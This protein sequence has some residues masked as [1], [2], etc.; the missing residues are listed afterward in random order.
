MAHSNC[1][2]TLT[3]SP[4]PTV[5]FWSLTFKGKNYPAHWLALSCSCIFLVTHSLHPTVCSRSVTPV[6]K[7]THLC[8]CIKEKPLCI[9][10]L[11]VHFLHLQW[12]RFQTKWV[13]FW[14][15]HAGKWKVQFFLSWTQ[16]LTSGIFLA[17]Y[18]HGNIASSVKQE[19]HYGGHMNTST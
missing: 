4:Y 1:E 12:P 3:G 16:M 11:D 18:L 15:T 2:P 19:N 17:A 13:F 5:L 9:F 6:G 14:I 7:Q 8:I 10:V